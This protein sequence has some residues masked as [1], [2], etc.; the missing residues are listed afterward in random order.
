MIWPLILFC[1]ISFSLTPQCIATSLL[2]IDP[3]WREEARALLEASSWLQ[4]SGPGH[5]SSEDYKTFRPD[6][7][8]YD[9]QA[10][11]RALSALSRWKPFTSAWGMRGVRPHSRAPLVSAL[12]PPEADLVSAETRALLRP[13]GQPL[14]WGRRRR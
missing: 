4:P 6:N 10:N 13:V 5:G 7:D 1:C 9:L 11:K 12:L 3:S 8:D 14:R 2:D